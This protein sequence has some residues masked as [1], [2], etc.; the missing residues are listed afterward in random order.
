MIAFSAVGSLREEI[1]PKDF[2][3]PDQVVDR[4]KGV[5]PWTYFGG[6]VVGHVGFA[7][8]F[9]KRLSQ[10][11]AAVGEKVLGQRGGRLHRGGTLICMGEYLHE[12][13]NRFY[14]CH[15]ICFKTNP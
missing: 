1:K 8:P 7:D 11:I 13:P 2:V 5:R 6:G 4:T 10:V 14:H 12:C 15:I 3:V 9:D